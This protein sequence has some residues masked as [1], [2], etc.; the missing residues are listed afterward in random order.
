M[1]VFVCVGACVM[2]LNMSQVD[3]GSTVTHE[4]AA[5]A[6]DSGTDSDSGAS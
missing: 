5:A 3:V 2:L 1:F 4:D 6:A